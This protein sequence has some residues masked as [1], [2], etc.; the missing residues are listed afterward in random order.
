METSLHRQIKE[1]FGAGPGARTEVV[2]NGFRIDAVSAEGELIEVQSGALGPLRAKLRRLL[3][4]HRIRVIKPVVLRR[5]VVRRARRDGKDLSSRLSPKRGAVLDVFDDL[6]GLTSVFPHPN[7]SVEVW[8]VEI[9]EVRVPRRRW[10]GYAVVDRRLREVA[11]KT[12][13]R[14]SA[15]LWTLL[16]EDVVDPFTTRDLADG[17]E[18]SLAFAQRV[19][20]CLQHAGAARLLGKRGRFQLYAR[21]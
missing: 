1:G 3:G 6:I 20:Y 8:G 7:L 9:D 19:A 2:L 13:L 11:D 4:G 5:R 10:P 21:G 12:V 14:D 15:A 18:R 17:L 16:P